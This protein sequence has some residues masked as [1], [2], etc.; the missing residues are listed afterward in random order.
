MIFVSIY[1]TS[2]RIYIYDVFVGVAVPASRNEYQSIKLQLESET[3]PPDRFGT[4][5]RSFHSLPVQEQAQLEKKRLQGQL[6]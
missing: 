5:P 4:K 1:C 6:G 3:F 2:M